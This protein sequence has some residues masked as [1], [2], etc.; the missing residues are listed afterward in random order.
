LAAFVTAIR[1]N[2]TLDDPLN[3]ILNVFHLFFLYHCKNTFL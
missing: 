1:V 3:F 2:Y